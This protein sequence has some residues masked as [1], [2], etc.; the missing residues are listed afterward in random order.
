[1]ANAL[2]WNAQNCPRDRA[3][4]HWELLGGMRLFR[5]ENGRKVYRCRCSKCNREYEVR[6]IPDEN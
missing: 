6:R 4:L 3:P 5:M 1:M 2:P